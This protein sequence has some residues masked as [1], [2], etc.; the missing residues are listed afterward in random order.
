MPVPV[1]SASLILVSKNVLVVTKKSSI[2]HVSKINEINFKINKNI[3]IYVYLYC[4]FSLW[5]AP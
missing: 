3:Y 4:M 5:F 2:M 1:Y